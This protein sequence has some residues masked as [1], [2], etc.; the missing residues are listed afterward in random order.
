MSYVMH[1]PRVKLYS[2]AIDKL[3]LFDNR[4]SMFSK[5]YLFNYVVTYPIG[6][7]LFFFFYVYCIFQS[8][9]VKMFI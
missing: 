4:K 5:I 3:I 8:K 2:Q 9:N 7:L 6:L 1:C